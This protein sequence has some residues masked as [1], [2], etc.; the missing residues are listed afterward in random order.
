MK[1]ILTFQKV[2]SYSS[3]GIFFLVTILFFSSYTSL[4]K[5]RRTKWRLYHCAKFLAIEKANTNTYPHSLRCLVD[6]DCRIEDGN[7]NL[8]KYESI[9]DGKDYVLFSVGNDGIPYTEDDIYAKK[10]DLSREY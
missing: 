2:V 1:S 4:K 9:D 5:E 10:Y 7:G 6:N 8:F 3:I